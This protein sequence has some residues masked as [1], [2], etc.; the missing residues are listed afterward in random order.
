VRNLRDLLAIEPGN[1]EASYVLAMSHVTRREYRR[2]C[3]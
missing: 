1:P 3:E 2:R